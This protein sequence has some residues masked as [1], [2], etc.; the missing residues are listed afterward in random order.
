ML[1]VAVVA[2]YLFLYFFFPPIIYINKCGNIIY[3]ALVPSFFLQIHLGLAY[4]TLLGNSIL[5]KLANSLF[6]ISA[7]SLIDFFFLVCYESI[8]A[9]LVAFLFKF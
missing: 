7:S 4:F 1:C 8:M 6:M 5:T 9:W 3:S 2:R